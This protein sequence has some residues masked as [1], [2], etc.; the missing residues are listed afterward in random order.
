[1]EQEAPY[2]RPAGGLYTSVYDYARFLQLWLEEGQQADHKLL[3][4]ES[5]RLALT[6]QADANYGL[7]WEVWDEPAGEDLLPAFG[8]GG[9]GGTIAIAV[10]E[11]D[12]MVLYFTQ[13]QGTD[14]RDQLRDMVLDTVG[15]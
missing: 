5:V 10:P 15:G 9:A 2:F 7:H 8:H 6:K 12:M 13:S 1:M 14:T 4:P 11:L 3:S